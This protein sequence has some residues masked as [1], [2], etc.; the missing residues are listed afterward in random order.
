MF[1]RQNHPGANL[2]LVARAELRA[3][4][5]CSRRD[6]S[7]RRNTRSSVAREEDARRIFD[8]ELAARSDAAALGSDALACVD[9]L[10]AERL[11]R[12][13]KIGRG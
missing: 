9:R 12:K 4:E 1:Y 10:E 11:L 6:R 5:R 3:D 13:S 8:V 2:A 7:S